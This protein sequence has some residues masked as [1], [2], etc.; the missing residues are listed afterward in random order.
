MS[1]A[2]RTFVAILCCLLVLSC[3]RSRR[4]TAT[5][6]SLIESEITRPTPFISPGLECP[7]V[8]PA[9]KAEV[10]GDA[11]VVGVVVNG[12]AR[13][14]LLDAMVSPFKHIVNDLIEGTP[15][16]VTYCNKNGCVRVFTD[17]SRGKPLKISLMGF[18]KGMLIRINDKTYEQ[19]TGRLF[20]SDSIDEF[21]FSQ[22]A[23][24]VLKWDDWKKAHPD[25]EIFTDS[26]RVPKKTT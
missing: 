7:P 18:G 21:P 9:E 12:K 25:T 14:Y 23:Y 3:N 19:E 8:Q 26:S 15:V 6:E 13:A 22:M 10:P 11:V 2:T 17:E 1:T 4:D 24:E 5:T 20:N 16:S